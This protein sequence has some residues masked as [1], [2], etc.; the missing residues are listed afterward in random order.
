[1]RDE[2]G[3]GERLFGMKL[4]FAV[5]TDCKRLYSYFFAVGASSAAGGFNTNCSPR[6]STPDPTP[7]HGC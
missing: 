2:G 6:E 3:G 5:R 4:H 1:M 7:S